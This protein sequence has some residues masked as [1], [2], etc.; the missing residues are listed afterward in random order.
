MKAVKKFFGFVFLVIIAAAAILGWTGYSKYASA[1]KEKPLDTAVSEI[2]SIK[3]YT[4][5][6]DIPQMYTD[7]V[8]AAEDRRFYYH[9]GF[10]IIGTARAIITDIKERKLVEGGSTITQQLAKNMYFIKDNSPT[11]KIAEIF[12]SFRIEKEYSKNEI[13]ELY[14]NGIY[15]GSGYYCLYDASMGY[16]GKAPRDMNDYES[17]LLAGIPNAP[18]AYSLKVNPELA[19]KRQD[20][21]ISSLVECGYINEEQGKDIVN[22]KN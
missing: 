15:Y 16:F 3:N 5:L 18:S 7:S 17:T 12:M 21:I 13:L 8:I 10:D 14:V 22:K 6:D 2:K 11:R 20:K 9:N 4:V 19:E 1:L